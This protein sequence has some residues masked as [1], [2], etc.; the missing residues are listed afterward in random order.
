MLQGV[1]K[2]PECKGKL[3]IRISAD[4]VSPHVYL[5]CDYFVLQLFF[6]HTLVIF[7]K[8]FWLSPGISI[9]CKHL[10][11][12]IG[13]RVSTAEV[14]VKEFFFSFTKPQR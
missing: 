5:F 12:I 8:L 13:D 9:S 1:M 2:C 7:F 14:N 10:V 4:D 6:V 11:M 3:Q